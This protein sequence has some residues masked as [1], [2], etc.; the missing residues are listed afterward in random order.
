[1]TETN[2]AKKVAHTEG[3]GSPKIREGLVV[4]DKMMKTVVVAVTR[5]VRDPQYKKFV[6][7]T[8]KYLAH[9][10]DGRCKV[11]DLVRIVETRPLSRNK[12][13][14]VQQVVREAV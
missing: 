6:K 12:R 13:W 9:D 5:Q 10:E 1:M 4:S 3:R 2:E 11:G 7:S 8:T 14:K